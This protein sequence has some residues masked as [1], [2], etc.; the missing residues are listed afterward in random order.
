MSASRDAACLG[1]ELRDALAVQLGTTLV[2]H[3]HAV[4][5]PADIAQTQDR[6][7]EGL[8]TAQGQTPC[9][10]AHP[11]PP[12][13]LWC[14][15][16]SHTLRAALKKS[17][18]GWPGNNL[19]LLLQEAPRPPSTLAHLSLNICLGQAPLTLIHKLLKHTAGTSAL[20]TTSLALRR[21][22]ILEPH[23]KNPRAHRRH[24]RLAHGLGLRAHGHGRRV[25][26]L[27]VGSHALL[28][29]ARVSL[30]LRRP[31]AC[32]AWRPCKVTLQL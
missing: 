11:T 17:A 4:L 32:Q 24:E 28:L 23:P 8:G 22:L 21:A 25:R 26:A 19:S 9:T 30:Q 12:C 27:G 31:L 7:G 18:Q 5:A 16:H 29:H 10:L 6:G 1:N 2:Q 3:N 20:S 13:S 14:Q 15:T